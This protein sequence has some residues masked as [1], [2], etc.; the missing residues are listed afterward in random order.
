MNTFDIVLIN[1]ISYMGGVFTGVGVFF[2][3]KD[4]IL[5]R[6]KSRD[7]LNKLYGNELARNLASLE[8]TSNYTTTPQLVHPVHPVIATA[9][10]LR[11][12]KI[13][14]D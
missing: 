7:N 6:S 2:K 10:S 5:I 14:T 1:I 13:T 4:S 12:I 3:F 9:P 11:E 8:D